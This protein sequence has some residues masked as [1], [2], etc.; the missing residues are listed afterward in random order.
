MAKTSK[1]STIDTARYVVFV[2]IGVGALLLKPHYHGLMEEFV[3]SYAGNFFISFSV[4][5]LASIALSRIGQGR[6]SAFIGAFL[7]VEAFE[8]TNGFGVMSNVF[9]PLDLIAN[10]LGI[11]AALA[12]EY[13]TRPANRRWSFKN[14]FLRLK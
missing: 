9:D 10:P 8:I 3:H 7:A 1:Q 5:F 12:A 13:L 6:F 2:L 11:A 4:Y 14:L